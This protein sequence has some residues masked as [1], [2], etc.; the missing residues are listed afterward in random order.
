[1]RKPRHSRQPPSFPRKR[2]PKG[3]AGK[4]ARDGARNA[5][6]AVRERPG[7]G[8]RRKRSALRRM[9]D[10]TPKSPLPHTPQTTNQNLTNYDHVPSPAQRERARV[11][12]TGR[13]GFPRSRGK[14]PKDK[15]GTSNNQHQ[16]PKNPNSDNHLSRPRRSPHRPAINPPQTTNRKTRHN[17]RCKP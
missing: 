7:E 16:N 5:V 15:G 13:T 6:G 11:R 3:R 4:G 10:S 14:C 17:N 12:V 8:L 9:M 1:M 2:E